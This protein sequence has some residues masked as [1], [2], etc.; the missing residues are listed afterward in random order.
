[1]KKS[2]LAF[3]FLLL[4][5]CQIQYDG[6]S[7]YIVKTRIVDID[8]N[9]LA[10]IPLSVRVFVSGLSDEI[11]FS[12]S[13]LNGTAIMIFPPPESDE[14]KF[15]ISFN[16]NLLN[17]EP[18]GYLA[19]TIYNIQKSN[20]DNYL[21]DT[22]TILLYKIDE[23]TICTI[24]KVQVSENTQI[25]SFST[26]AI[27]ADTDVNFE[28]PENIWFPISF[29][30]PKNQSFTISYSVTDYNNSPPVITDYTTEI[31]AETEP[32]TYTITY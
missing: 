17:F 1:M 31:A 25:T 21:F 30:V 24:L 5:S 15:S 14:A 10:N 7:K 18:S 3:T 23:V 6:E 19:K 4:F 32:L 26:T 11:S 22:G 8:G 9:P 2:L 29:W 20:F 27:T 16:T 13:D 28:A 12:N